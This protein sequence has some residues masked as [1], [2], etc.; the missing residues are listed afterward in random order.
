MSPGGALLSTFSVA[1]PGL[2]V[3]LQGASPASLADRK[4]Q[5]EIGPNALL[6]SGGKVI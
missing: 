2:P 1:P 6:G 4:G 3:W 5:S